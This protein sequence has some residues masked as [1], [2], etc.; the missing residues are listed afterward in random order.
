MC[1]KKICTECNVSYKSL[2][3]GS[4]YCSIEC[5]Q[6]GEAKRRKYIKC[7]ACESPVRYYPNSDHKNQKNIFCSN[8]CKGE[9]MKNHSQTLGLRKRA[10]KMRESRNEDTWKKGIETRKLNGNIIDWNVAEWKQYWRRCND[11][12][13]KIRDKMLEDWDG[14]DYIDGENIRENLALSHTHADYPTLDHVIP[15]SEGFRQ[16]LSP[17]EITTPENLKWTKRRN[18]SKKY[19][20]TI[21]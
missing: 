12:T 1:Y 15:R 10:E 19:N 17:Y 14:I 8:I 18:N 16:G 7:S 20:K 2:G 4:K 6:K 13:R 9:W 3:N 5:R 11:L 21:G